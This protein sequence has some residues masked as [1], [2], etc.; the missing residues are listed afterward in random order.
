[1]VNDTYV[2]VFR[3]TSEGGIMAFAEAQRFDQTL[4]RREGLELADMDGNGLLD[5]VVATLTNRVIVLLNSSDGSSLDFSAKRTLVTN[6]NTLSVRAGDLNGDGKPDLAYTETTTDVIS[7]QLNRNCISPVLEPQNGLGVCDLLPY[8]LS[9]TEAIGVT[10]VWESS[11]DGNTFTTLGA[12]ADSTSTFTTANEAYYRVKVSSSHNG[13]DCVEAISN[14]VQVR[15]PDGFVPDKPTIIDQN[16]EEPICFGQRITLRAQ[17]VNARFFWTGPGGF[18][19]N[20]QNPVIP[21]ASKANEGLYVLYVQASEENGGC[22]SDTATTFIKV[23]EPEPISITASTPAV[24]FEGG[25]TQLSVETIEG[26]VYAW[27]RDGQVIDGANGPTHT[28]NRPGSYVAIIRNETGCTRESAPFRVAQAEVQIP[29]SICLNESLQLAVTPDSING[30]PVRY[31]WYFGDSNSAEGASEDHLYA[32]A[33]NYGIQL[34]I[35]NGE[36]NVSDSYSQTLE[37]IPIPELIITASNGFLCPDEQ[38]RLEASEGFTTYAWEHGE[39]GPQISVSEAGI[40]TLTVTT[41]AGCTETA[42]YELT[43]GQPPQAEVSASSDRIDLGD[44][45]QLQASGGVAYRWTADASLSDTT[46]AN[47]T[48]RPLITTTYTCTVINEQ[49]CQTE[50][51]YT[52]TVDRSLDV[53]PLQAFTPNGDGRHDQWYIERMDLFPNCSM[54]IFDRQ[55]AQLTQITDY[56]NEAGWDGTINGRPMPEGVYFYLIDCGDE[57]GRKTGSVTI[58]R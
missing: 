6:E 52:I 38:V 3:N 51:S 57:A 11:A 26:A 20:E 50:L 37:V 10:Y 31:R 33:G 16:P 53:E 49:G 44:T 58:L 45:L 30:E 43:E 54:T 15:R 27:Q 25:Q 13:F 4:I 41:E 23:S 19:S 22:V 39:S 55:G 9:V 46:I 24:F 21:N 29:A 18:T 47:P 32:A 42:I 1:M 40:Y 34:D 35:L 28:A 56:S 5:I 36:G 14:V 12:A 8:Q 2:G 17:N 7:M 48:A